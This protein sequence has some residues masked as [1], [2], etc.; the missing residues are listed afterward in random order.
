PSGLSILEEQFFGG[1]EITFHHSG[2]ILPIFS[3]SFPG[4]FFFITSLNPDKNPI[5]LTL[6]IRNEK[7]PYDCT[8]KIR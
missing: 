3:N 4:L 8:N 6:S 5:L 1:I 7:K 2:N